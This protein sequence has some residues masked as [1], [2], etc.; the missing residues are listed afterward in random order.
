MLEE[1]TT[2][3]P[4]GPRYK[5]FNP[6]AFQGVQVPWIVL[7]MHELSMGARV[8]W[9]VVAGLS[10]QR[11]YCWASVP[12]LAAK[13]GVQPRQARRYCQELHERDLMFSEERPGQTP[14]RTLLE[15]P[16]LR[17]AANLPLS[18]LTGG[19]VRSDRGGGQIR[20][21]IKTPR[22][23]HLGQELFPAGQVESVQAGTSKRLTRAMDVFAGMGLDGL[24]TPA[25]DLHAKP[26]K[27]AAS[28]Y[29]SAEDDAIRKVVEGC[30]IPYSADLRAKLARKGKFYGANGFT[31]AAA[32]ERARRKVKDKPALRPTSSGW[33][34]TVVENALKSPT[35]S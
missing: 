6:L 5:P 8:M 25:E 33:F 2:T 15:H 12:S 16:I 27:P 23:K 7:Q 14:L 31:I 32:I 13:L 26:R 24:Q 18:D 9:G 20:P 28:A 21:P 29:S 11:G 4:S 17:A 19:A 34:L 35:G 1:N 30:G 3:K 10:A 22:L